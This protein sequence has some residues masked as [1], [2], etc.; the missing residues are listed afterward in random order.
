[1]KFRKVASRDGEAFGHESLKNFP[2]RLDKTGMPMLDADGALW[3]K[4]AQDGRTVTL[5]LSAS[6]VLAPN[7]DRGLA[8]E[9]ILSRVG[10]VLKSPKHSRESMREFKQDW[11]LLQ[12]FS[13][14]K[15]VAVSATNN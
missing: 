6:N 15:A 4:V 12:Q 1:M 13:S 3:M 10:E 8:Y 5:G 9:L 14:R 2:K 7:S 11:A